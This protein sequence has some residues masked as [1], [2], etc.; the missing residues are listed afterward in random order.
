VISA[1][2]WR[3]PRGAPREAS[4]RR[5]LA[6][7]A[8]KDILKHGSF[9]GHDVASCLR[10]DELSVKNV[11]LPH[12]SE[13]ELGSAVLWECKERFGFEVSPDR[14]H[15]IN[16]GEV[17]QGSEVRDELILMAATEETVAAHLEMLAGMGL[18]PVHIDAEPTALFRTYERFLRRAEDESAITIIADIG[19]ASTKVVIARGRTILMVKNIDLGGQKFNEN[20]AKQL[21]LEVNEAAH[22]RQRNSGQ[23]PPPEA[24]GQAERR[25]GDP[26]QWSIHD[27]VREPVQ[28]LARE[29]SLCVRYCSVTFRG[30][31][32][33]HV[34]LAGG[35][36]YDPVLVK[37]LGENL[38][39][40][41]RLGEPLKGAD[42][43]RAD[44]GGDRRRELMEWSVAAGL[45]IRD[46]VDAGQA[47][48]EPSHQASPEEG[49]KAY[50]T[51]RVSA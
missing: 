48:S 19:F 13:P 28:A 51:S 24:S 30:L 15:Y 9:R 2:G 11:R 14:I 43:G 8:V 26:V 10:C 33:T 4:E 38:E 29:I 41:C 32:P 6:V 1:A 49:R 31:R 46:L 42:L 7:E 5:R 22:L 18:R 50:E 16:A 34:T 45:A 44:L 20:V 21:G 25:S 23:A 3:F 39:C 35:E 12:M 27:A 40:P 17:R 37:L 36:A 47:R